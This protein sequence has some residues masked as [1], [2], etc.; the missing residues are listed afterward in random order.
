MTITHQVGPYPQTVATTA[1]IDL[2]L[3]HPSP[4]LLPAA[5]LAALAGEHIGRDRLLW[6]YGT[7]RGQRGFREA[8]AAFLR[9]AGAGPASAEQLL[10]TGGTSTA[11]AIASQMLARPGQR[12]L[13]GDPTYF[14]ARGIFEA[15]GLEVLGVP[16]DAAGIDVDALARE[17]GRDPGAVALVYCMPSFH[18]PCGVTLSRQRRERLIELAEEHDVTILADEPYNLLAYRGAPPASL[19]A[20]D[21][22]RGRVVS[23]GSFSKILA[24]GV[25][26]GWMQASEALLARI[27]GHGALESGGGLNPVMAAAVHGAIESGFQREHLSRLR[28]R[29]T[30]TS[31]ALSRALRRRLPAAV[32]EEPAGGYFAW[33]D[34]GRGVSSSAML[35]RARAAGVG[36]TPGTRCAVTGDFDRFVRLCF[37]FYEAEEIERAIELLARVVGESS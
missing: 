26:L 16:V 27:A 13:C 35:E 12:V 20:A 29:Y 33:I 34:L 31:R 24:P 9:A 19:F 23:L 5:E 7:I 14:L 22:G 30:H 1:C 15:H 3:G 17:L 18:N 4:S 25:R 2:G 32:F 37:S 10:V 21:Q 6:Q 36:Y 28:Q 8:L 11:L